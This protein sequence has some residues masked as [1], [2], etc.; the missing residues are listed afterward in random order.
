M[1]ESADLVMALSKGRILKQTLPL[2]EKAGITPL[3]DIE[4]SRKLIFPTNLENLKLLVVR[5]SDVPTYV[6]YGAA[7]FGVAGKD[8]LLE[9]NYKNIFELL[10]LKIGLCKLMVAVRNGETLPAQHI[11]VASKYTK[12]AAAHFAK[13]GKQASIIKLYGS[14][15]LAP[16][17]GLSNCIVDLVDT[18]KTLE[19]NGLQAIETVCEISSRLVVNRASFILKREAISPLINRIKKSLD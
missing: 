17:V 4:K 2:L 15:E 13:L 14:M 12:S 8:I 3:E 11:K 16:L 1:K 19:A 10:D 9:G 5:P 6:E 18:G 7:D